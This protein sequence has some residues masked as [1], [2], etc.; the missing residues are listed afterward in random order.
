MRLAR[1]GIT[2]TRTTG[3]GSTGWLLTMP[4]R[5]GVHLSP[6]GVDNRKVV[7]AELVDLVRAWTRNRAVRSMVELSRCRTIHRLDTPTDAGEIELDDDTVTA[8]IAVR[9]GPPVRR[10]WRA[11]RCRLHC[12]CGFGDAVLNNVLRAGGAPSSW[13]SQVD[14]AAA[15]AQ[16]VRWPSPDARI[17]G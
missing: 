11:V 4:G 15:A 9:H 13:T 12:T 16:A 17:V 7:P 10:K 8:R 1:A 14:H 6:A 3:S 5:P 2:L